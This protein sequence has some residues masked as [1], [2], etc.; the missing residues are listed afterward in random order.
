MPSHPMLYMQG[1]GQLT[2]ERG[3]MWWHRF[4][5]LNMDPYPRAWQYRMFTWSCFSGSKNIT[6]VVRNSMAYPQTLRKKTPVARA[7]TVTQVLE[8]PLHND[9]TEASEEA[10]GPQVPKLTMKQRREKLF[11][12]LYMSGLE[13][14]PPK[15]V[16]S[17]HSLLAKYHDIFSLEP[18]KLGF[19][20]STEHVIKATNDTLFKEHFRWIPPPLVE[21]IHAH[22][23]EMLDSGVIHSNQSAWCNAVVLVQKKEGGLCFL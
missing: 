15:L 13:S 2:L 4:Y 23:W 18:S 21:E 16:A 22:L 6:V 10:Y 7:V 9:L 12:E 1:W 3:S 20:H 17:A 14:W 19:T 8:L 11:Q 5:M